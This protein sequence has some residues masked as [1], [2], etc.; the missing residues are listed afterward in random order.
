M[1]A[2]LLHVIFF[3]ILLGSWISF[4]VANS[5]DTLIYLPLKS[6][7]LPIEIDASSNLWGQGASLL[8]DKNF[9]PDFIHKLVHELSMW[10]I[11]AGFVYGFIKRPKFEIPQ[12]RNLALLLAGLAVFILPADSSDLWGYIA[13]GWQQVAYDANPFSSVVAH[14]D[15]WRDIPMLKNIL[16]QHNPSP[17]G[18]LFMLLAKYLTALSA[19]NLWLA[20]FLFKVVNFGIF[21]ATLL[22]LEKI[23]A[24][25]KQGLWIYT[26]FALNPLVISEFLWNAHNDLIM[27]F[28]IL[29]SLCLATK[30]KFVSSIFVLTLVTLV[31]YLSLVLLPLIILLAIRENKWRD[32]LLGLALSAGLAWSLISHYHLPEIDYSQISDN[33]SLSHK[34]LFDSCNSLFKYVSG[35]DLPR[36]LRW[37]FLGGFG[38]FALISYYRF[39]KETKPDVFRASFWLIFVLLFIASPK[40]HSWYLLMLLPLGLLVEA[41]LMVILSLT[42]LL[43]LTFIDQANILNYVLM[44]VLPCA[45]FFSKQAR[46]LISKLDLQCK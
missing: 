17:Y 25:S 44:T 33:I 32:L 29:L 40:F 26:A 19:G 16:W 38:V 43:S 9:K 1:Q 30:S 37:L 2:Y 8:A 10:L 15:G 28:G 46:P 24:E 39:V 14:I 12:I 11:V 42:H 27:G 6:L 22:L 3:L 21:V 13:R 20:M 31:K 35:Q 45:L 5:S 18:P 23:L 41:E 7:F 4:A 36:V 34:S